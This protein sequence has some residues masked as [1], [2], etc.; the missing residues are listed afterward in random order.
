M[1]LTGFPLIFAA[2]FGAVAAVAVT[3]LC[4]NRFGRVRYLLRATGVLLAEVL[5]LLTS[6]LAANRSEQFYPTWGTLLDASTADDTTIDTTNGTTYRSGPGDLDHELT[7]RADGRTGAAQTF[8][9]QSA[10]WRGWALAAAPAV[11]TPPGYL[12]HPTWSY[13]AV[14]VIDRGP[15]GWTPAQEQSAVRRTIA[16]GVSAVAV[17]VTTTPATAA[18]ALAVALPGQLERDLRVTSHRWSIIASAADAAL[19]QNAVAAGAV[20]YPSVAL[21]PGGVALDPAPPAGVTYAAVVV[22]DTVAAHQPG[23]QP[24]PS[25][26]PDALYTALFWAITRTPPPLAADVAPGHHT[27]KR[28]IPAPSGDH[29]A[30]SRLRPSP[31][32]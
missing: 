6:G 25:T 32:R 16:A 18:P 30:S 1:A 20:R 5:L 19:A 17:S 14:V 28:P 31:R 29:D 13:S 8:S 9:W 23:V 22:G 27:P 12:L 2:A 15:T 3:M 4:W 7:E 10:D 26:A 21:L 24:L 11:F